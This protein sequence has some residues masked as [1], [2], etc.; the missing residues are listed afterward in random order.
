PELKAE[1]QAREIVRKIQEERKKL[2]TKLDEKID[3]TLED[4]PEKFTEY[5]KKE[6]LISF[7]SKGEF[8]VKKA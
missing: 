5:I 7:I 6:T 3:V 1:G 8:S 4:W 2:G